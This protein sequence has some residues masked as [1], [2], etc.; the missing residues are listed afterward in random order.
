MEYEINKLE[1]E[2]DFIIIINALRIGALSNWRLDANLSKALEPC[3]SFK[4]KI[5]NHIFQEGNKSVDDLANM[6]IDKSLPTN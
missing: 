5:I 6:G 3:K 4:K 1:I 2:G